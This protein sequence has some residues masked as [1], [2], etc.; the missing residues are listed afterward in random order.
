MDT[1]WER[2]VEVGW[3]TRVVTVTAE[4][5]ITMAVFVLMAVVRATGKARDAGVNWVTVL[6][7]AVDVGSGGTDTW[8][9]L[10]A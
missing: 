6:N 2:V 9:A 5:G 4:T 10:V 7:W 8:A 1:V 3:V